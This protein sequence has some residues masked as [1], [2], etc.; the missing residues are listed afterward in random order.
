[1]ALSYI[2]GVNIELGKTNR[3]K[4]ILDINKLFVNKPRQGM[5]KKHDKA[6][7]C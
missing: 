7:S 2:N 5:S 4:I 6:E 3:W 1:M